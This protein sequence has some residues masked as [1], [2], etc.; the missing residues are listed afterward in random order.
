MRRLGATLFALAVAP[1]TV[2]VGTLGIAIATSSLSE[3]VAYS[4]YLRT[5]LIISTIVA[6]GIAVGVGIPT[7]LI[8]M[9]IRKTEVEFYAIAGILWVIIPMIIFSLAS[10]TRPAQWTS[11]DFYTTSI[12]ALA[13]LSVAA[14]F[15]WVYNRLIAD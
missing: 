5:Q 4:G 9:Y 14:L 11:Q 6:Y 12:F 7:H 3:L 1:L 10:G 13:G 8:L 2:P 15:G